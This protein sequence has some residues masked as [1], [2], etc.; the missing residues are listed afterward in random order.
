MTTKKKTKY[1]IVTAD[2][3]SCDSPILL[4][5]QSYCRAVLGCPGLPGRFPAVLPGTFSMLAFF[6]VIQFPLCN[7][8]ITP[9]GE[10]TSERE[11]DAGCRKG[12]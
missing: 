3:E 6:I 11:I 7:I 9:Y 4:Y 2:G 5:L 1:S 10:M 8:F 12:P